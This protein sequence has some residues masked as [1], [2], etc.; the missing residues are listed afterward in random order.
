MKNKKLTGQKDTSFPDNFCIMV[1]RGWRR[2][3][4]NQDPLLLP[5]DGE[6]LS[7]PTRQK[8][9]SSPRVASPS[10]FPWNQEFCAPLRSGVQ[11][12]HHFPFHSAGR[13]VGSP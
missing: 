11:T 3:F 4:P 8:A 6:D 7:L 1:V 2:H 13:A 12:T 5:E 9:S 10:L